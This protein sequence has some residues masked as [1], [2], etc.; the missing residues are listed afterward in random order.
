MNKWREGR[1]THEL[2]NEQPEIKVYRGPMNQ[3]RIKNSSLFRMD[4]QDEKVRQNKYQQRRE[5][6]TH[7]PI[8]YDTDP[9]DETGGVGMIMTSLFLFIQSTY[10]CYKNN[11]PWCSVKDNSLA[12]YGRN[13]IDIVDNQMPGCTHING[14]IYMNIR[15]AVLIGNLKV[16]DSVISWSSCNILSTQDHDTD[17]IVGVIHPTQ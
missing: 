10:L 1:Q 4:C 16:P 15:T 13:E 9:R 8:H 14:Y 17:V 3:W 6:F 12:D 2:F 11:L 7:A 5:H